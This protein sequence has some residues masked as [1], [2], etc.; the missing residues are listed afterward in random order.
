MIRCI[1]SDGAIL[2]GIPRATLMR[3]LATTDCVVSPPQ[4]A[5]DMPVTVVLFAGETD[6]HVLEKMTAHYSTVPD[7][8]RDKREKGNG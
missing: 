7:E 8:I 6:A 3:L 5:D 2:I 1:D 4:D